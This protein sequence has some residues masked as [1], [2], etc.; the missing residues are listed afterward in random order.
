MQHAGAVPKSFAEKKEFKARLHALREDDDFSNVDEAVTTASLAFLSAVRDHC[1][2][3]RACVRHH[4]SRRWLRRAR[5]VGCGTPF[6]LCAC[7][8]VR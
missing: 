6:V 8:C 1:A 2:R 7:D 5:C 4:L 3:A